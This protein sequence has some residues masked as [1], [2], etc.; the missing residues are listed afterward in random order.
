MVTTT[1]LVLG[2]FLGSF[3][4]SSILSFVAT[5]MRDRLASGGFV[6]VNRVA[7][8]LIMVSGIL[9]FASLITQ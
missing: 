3:L 6:W 2:V 7:G 4:W 9:A 5:L 8:V 1:S